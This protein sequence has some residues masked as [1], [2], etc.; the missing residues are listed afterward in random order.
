[1][2]RKIIRE[3]TGAVDDDSLN[4]MVFVAEP[5]PLSWVEEFLKGRKDFQCIR[6]SGDREKLTVRERNLFGSYSKCLEVLGEMPVLPGAIFRSLLE[7]MA[8]PRFVLNVKTVADSSE[9][10]N[11]LAELLAR[12]LADRGLGVVLDCN[13][14][15][16]S[17][18]CPSAEP[19]ANLV[20]PDKK[21]L[22]E[23][24]WSIGGKTK[25]KDFMPKVLTLWQKLEPRF[26]PLQYGIDG[27]ID[28]PISGN[29]YDQLIKKLERKPKEPPLAVRWY[30]ES[31]VQFGSFRHAEDETGYK[32]LPARFR[33]R[34]LLTLQ[35][36]MVP[37]EKE[38][39]FSAKFQEFFRQTAI[40]ANA[41]FASAIV[42]RTGNAASGWPQ[43]IV[44]DYSLS[45]GPWWEG[46][47]SLPYWLGWYGSSYYP[48]V[49]E[50]LASVPEAREYPEQGILL[51]LDDFPQNLSQ[52]TGKFPDLPKE[53]ILVETTSQVQGTIRSR[54]YE[55]AM[56]IPVL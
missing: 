17:Y 53:L 40:E 52:L 43:Y 46:L 3:W 24:E 21:Q 36:D 41:F 27:E 38:A 54:S 16:I 25:P 15:Q 18:I 10:T 23:I 30:G 8:S 2:L 26:L 51:K 20:S 11:T 44:D 33:P 37:F 56:I 48:L 4:F 35:I 5:V 13:L 29:N 7:A 28:C 47:P 45:V 14:G 32:R 49:K 39:D 42:I 1:M 22:L 19:P 31:P 50:S 34:H 9:R 6:D 12:Q 55:P